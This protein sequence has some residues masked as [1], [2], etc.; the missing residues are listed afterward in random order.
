MS[1]RVSMAM[2]NVPGPR[3]VGRPAVATP[4]S[5]VKMFSDVHRYLNQ[6]HSDIQWLR[7]MHA[8][9]DV[10]RK[11][12]IAECQRQL[13]HDKSERSAQ[14]KKFSEEMQTHVNRKMSTLHHELEDADM[15]MMNKENPMNAHD[16]RKLQFQIDRMSKEL[17]AMRA[18]LNLVA[19][20]MDV[21]CTDSYPARN[22]IPGED[23]EA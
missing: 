8:R 4:P 2:A 17:A 3:D 18:G 15:M 6:R 22:L 7:S 21:M 23:E 16:R 9:K 11:E 1:A 20:A 13:E 10:Q 12:A 5:G 14:M 19:D